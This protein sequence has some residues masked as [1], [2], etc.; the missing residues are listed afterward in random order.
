MPRKTDEPWYA[1][2]RAMAYVYSLFAMKPS[3]ILTE[4]PASKDYGVDLLVESGERPRYRMQRPLG[5]EIKGYREFPSTNELNRRIARDPIQR[6][7]DKLR[8]PLLVC[9]VQFVKLKAVYCWLVEP[10]IEDRKA[11]L[12]QP[13]EYEWSEFEEKAVD[14]ILKR[15]D[16]FYEALYDIKVKRN[17]R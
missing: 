16:L 1:E 12:Q 15:V 14:E 3:R 7:V 2:K 6:V 11:A 4:V 8:M 13:D 5:V 10:I 17:R 9:V